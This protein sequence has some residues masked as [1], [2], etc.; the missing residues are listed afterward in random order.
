MEVFGQVCLLLCGTCLPLVS[1]IKQ[2]VYY[3][4]LTK[5]QNKNMTLCALLCP[6][7]QALMVGMEK[8]LVLNVVA[9]NWRVTVVT[10]FAFWKSN[11]R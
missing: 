6:Y 9:L 1:E 10:D 5:K 2:I 7:S 11:Y 3:L 4:I 8:N